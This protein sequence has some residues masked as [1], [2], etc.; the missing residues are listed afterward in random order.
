[1]ERPVR[2]NESPVWEI[3]VN[4]IRSAH[5][6]SLLSHGEVCEV[7]DRPQAKATK[8]PGGLA[9][10]RHPTPVCVR[11]SGDGMVGTTCTAIRENC[12]PRRPPWAEAG[13]SQ[14]VRSSDE[15]GNDRRAKGH[16]KEEMR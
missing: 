6:T 14:S 11:M 1:M 10:K 7:V 16:R 13:S 5:R 2:N 12:P 9:G 15:A 3:N 4:S 8:Q